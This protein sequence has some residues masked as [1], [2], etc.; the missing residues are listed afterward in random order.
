MML[1]ARVCTCKVQKQCV[2]RA[3]AFLHTLWL[4]HL[5]LPAVSMGCSWIGSHL[6][7]YFLAHA[8]PGALNCPPDAP[9]FALCMAVLLRLPPQLDLH[10][11][12]P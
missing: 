9:S 3:M 11:H 1:V 7:L 10:L 2:S 8:V 5:C 6:V 4:S 12:G